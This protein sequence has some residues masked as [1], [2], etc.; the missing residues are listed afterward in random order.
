MTNK[1][2]NYTQKNLID[3]VIRQTKAELELNFSIMSFENLQKMENNDDRYKSSAFLQA[4]F[5]LKN[6][7]LF[8]FVEKANSDNIEK[9]SCNCKDEGVANFLKSVY[10]LTELEDE[11]IA[12][13]KKKIR[14]NIIKLEKA[15]EE[16]DYIMLE[17]LPK[18]H[19]SS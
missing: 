1:S 3:L 5:I 8:Q 16:L 11:E 17:S 10:S 2:L 19:Y 12:N 9:I 4:Y 7:E 15:I 13:E 14:R 18:N 6:N